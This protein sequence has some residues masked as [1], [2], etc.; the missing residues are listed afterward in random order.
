MAAAAE[1]NLQVM[2]KGVVALVVGA[3]IVVGC[4]A[5]TPVT[6]TTQLPPIPTLAPPPTPG[7]P[8]FTL[9][10]GASTSPASSGLAPLP[11]LPVGALQPQGPVTLATV[12]R[13]VD[14]DTIHVSINGTD[15]DLRYIGMDA[16]ETV[17]PDEPVQPGGPEASQANK[18][19]VDGRQVYLEKDVSETDRYGRLLRYVWIRNFEGWLMVDEQLVLEG[20]ARSKAYPP[21]TRYQ[22]WLDAA[23]AAAQQ[24]KVGIWAPGFLPSPTPFAVAS[25]TGYGLTGS[26]GNCDPSYP[27]VCIPPPPPDLD[28]TDIPYRDFPVLPPD[29]QHFDGD[30]NGLG[31][32]FV[33]SPGHV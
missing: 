4:G 16:P 24:A 13:V 31:C 17:N 23:Q 20:W 12:T 9:K 18:N 3:T 6:P 19:L 8:T 11:S 28:C 21:D 30:H 25:G 5:V 26:R 2:V 29:D 32:E 10:P 33:A 14:G 22:A 15:Y 7:L 27:T 1:S